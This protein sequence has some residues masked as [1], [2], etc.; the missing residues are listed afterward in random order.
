MNSKDREII[1]P[2]LMSILNNFLEEDYFDSDE[3]RYFKSKNID[4]VLKAVE[5]LQVFKIKT[6]EE[7][8]FYI[9]ERID[10]SELSYFKLDKWMQL[11]SSTKGTQNFYTETTSESYMSSGLDDGGISESLG[12]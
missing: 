11:G 12:E 9:E 3:E 1:E 6:I 2:F 8:K 5:L 4:I 10:E 7:I